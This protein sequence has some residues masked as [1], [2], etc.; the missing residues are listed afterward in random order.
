[1]LS[2]HILTFSS[3]TSYTSTTSKLRNYNCPPI[4][5]SYGKNRKSKVFQPNT[6]ITNYL[7][8]FMR[9]PLRNPLRNLLRKEVKSF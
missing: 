7:A 6:I 5:L 9:H 1:M 3:A 4:N 2:V 8:K